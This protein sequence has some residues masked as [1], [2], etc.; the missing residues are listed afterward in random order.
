MVGYLAIVYAIIT[1]V[2]FFG[3]TLS[4][5]ELIGCAIVLT[6]TI[7]LGWVKSR[8][9]KAQA[10]QTEQQV[11][12]ENDNYISDDFLNSNK[13][14]KTND[15]NLPLGLSVCKQESVRAF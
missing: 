2:C 3:D 13:M 8:Q 10:A 6:I 12:L 1:D 15:L 14:T 4:S 9:S 5:I 11:H 7:I